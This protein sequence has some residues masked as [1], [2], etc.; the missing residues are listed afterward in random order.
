MAMKMTDLPRKVELRQR[1]AGQGIEKGDA[2]RRDRGDDETVD[3]PADV[4]RF[5]EHF[6]V[7][8]ER[9]RVRNDRKG[10]DILGMLERGGRH[11]DE[12]KDHAQSA[13]QEDEVE[14]KFRAG[15]LPVADAHI[16]LG[17]TRRRSVWWRL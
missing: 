9:R 1:V 12:G 7:I 14:Q 6:A 15:F 8:V 17:R 5:V 16:R 10:V 4:L 11:P 3:E 2:R 13:D